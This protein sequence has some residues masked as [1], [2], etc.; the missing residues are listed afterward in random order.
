MKKQII[1]KSI[2]EIND[3]LIQENL[4]SKFNND[5]LEKIED[6][7]KFIPTLYTCNKVH[8]Y[9]NSP[10]IGEVQLILDE[11]K[12]E[13]SLKELVFK[14]DYIENKRKN[15][16]VSYKYIAK[17]ID[18]DEKELKRIIEN[19]QKCTFTYNQLCQFIAW[20]KVNNIREILDI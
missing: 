4:K 12:F 19:K 5:E 18:I 14:T 16:K 17:C 11:G 1:F 6:F 7:I 9:Y 20:I 10:N 8:R 13:N 2:K 3:F 15:A